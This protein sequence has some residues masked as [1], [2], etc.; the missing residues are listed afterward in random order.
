[1]VDSHGRTIRDL[2][3]SITDRCN[4]RCVY[5]ME[6]DVRFASQE[7]LLTVDEIIRV[8]TVAESLGVR[9]VRLTGGEP[10]LHPHL[11]ALIA[12][13]SSASG[14][15][16]AMITNASLLKRDALREW[17]AAGLKRMT[18]SID[19]LRPDRF[20][21]LTRSSA[22]PH[23]V[24]KGVELS[25]IE[26][27]TPVKLNAVL[28]RGFNDDEAVELAALSRT[29]GVEMRFIEYMPLDSGHAWDSS[30]WVSASETRTTIERTFPLIPCDDDD[31]SSTARTFRFAD[32]RADSPAR[33]GFIAPVSTPFCGACSR[34]RLTADGQVR[35][36]L[37]STTEW[38]IRSPLR[39]G[40]TDEELADFLIDATW[41]KQPGH[42][43]SSLGFR[44]PE[45]PM[46]AIGG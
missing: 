27:L 1:M 22:S 25:L 31:P 9:K 44:Q 34:L 18:V 35:P 11:T 43:I 2:R 37:F 23:Q 46:S 40:A 5:C 6:P 16:I 15:E 28:I 19:S 26:G 4:F 7:A 42:G 20:A 12:G 3:I 32:L 41:T 29:F 21:R 13:L 17:K 36:C 14:V 10:T 38:D 24:L 33:I 39:N 30:K 8:A 45:R